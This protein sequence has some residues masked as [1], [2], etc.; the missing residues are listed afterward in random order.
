MENLK[1]V[2]KFILKNYYKSIIIIDLYKGGKS[3]D[4]YQ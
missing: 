4:N 1:K 3:G 2:D